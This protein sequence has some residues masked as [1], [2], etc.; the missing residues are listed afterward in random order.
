MEVSVDG[1]RVPEGVLEFKRDDLEL[2]SGICSVVE[3][4]GALELGS[5]LIIVAVV[6]SDR[7]VFSGSGT[8]V[9]CSVSVS[10]SVVFIISEVE[11]TD[12]VDSKTSVVTKS[13][14]PS[15][16]AGSMLVKI[17]VVVS[18]FVLVKF[19]SIISVFVV[20]VS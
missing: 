2:V 14:D 4:C 10:L 8:N 9:D 5:L 1:E 18:R 11:R 20:V 3:L 6:V 19:S 17:F 15:P 16:L 7:L 12:P 13:P